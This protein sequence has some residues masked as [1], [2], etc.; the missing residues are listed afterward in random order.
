MFRWILGLTI[1]ALVIAAFLL[2]PLGLWDPPSG[3][4][5]ILLVSL[6]LWIILFGLSA[7][8]SSEDEGAT[9]PTRIGNTLVGVL[10][11]PITSFLTTAVLVWSLFKGRPKKFEVIAKA[12]PSVQG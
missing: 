8:I 3:L 2:V 1:E 11:A 6:G 4:L 10:L 5:P 7:W 12:A 9:L